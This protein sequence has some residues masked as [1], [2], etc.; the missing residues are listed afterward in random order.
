M[1]EDWSDS[2]P[3][4]GQQTG[5]KRNERRTAR[6]TS[7]AFGNTSGI[8]SS[9][10]SSQGVRHNEILY[11]H[12]S[13]LPPPPPPPPQPPDKHVKFQPSTRPT[14]SYSPTRDQLP[15]RPPPAIEYIP[16]THDW[17]YARSTRNTGRSSPPL[18]S[19]PRPRSPT[20]PRTR[21]PHSPPRRSRSQYVEHNRPSP[22]TIIRHSGFPNR[23]PSRD[24]RNYEVFDRSHSPQRHASPPPRRPYSPRRRE[25]SVPNRDAHSVRPDYAFDYGPRQDSGAT[26]GR[27]TYRPDSADRNEPRVR[28]GSA[29]NRERYFR[30][31][32][33]RPREMEGRPPIS[34]QSNNPA[35]IIIRMRPPEQRIIVQEAPEPAPSFV[36]Y[37]QDRDTAI[38]PEEIEVLLNQQEAFR[39]QMTH[40]EDEL[41][42]LRQN[43]R[44]RNRDQR[45][46]QVR[47]RAQ[48]SSYGPGCRL[49]TIT[50]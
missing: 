3:E 34:V 16:Y 38:P 46:N 26:F 21:V 47:N 37:K 18:P 22:P 27:Q 50:L 42:R 9:R 6:D 14:T 35:P 49:M 48:R 44:I 30:D 13:P 28:M 15:T 36:P 40:L 20:P 19:R 1:T 7:N 25:Y 33:Q 31:D 17:R 2:D 10:L 32:A 45:E 4:S 43:E 12:R 29:A 23:S 5:P 8:R 24:A 41:E 39:R 11:R